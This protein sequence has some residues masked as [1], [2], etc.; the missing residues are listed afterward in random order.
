MDH[1]NI[2]G[3]VDFEDTVRELLVHSVIVC[4]CLTLRSAIGG[5]VLLVMEERIKVVLGESSP[6]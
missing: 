1:D 2:A 4:P 5:L 6:P 3:L